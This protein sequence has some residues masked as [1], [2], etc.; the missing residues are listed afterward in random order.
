MALL[1]RPPRR[2]GVS[3]VEMLV[4]V[5]VFALGITVELSVL[6]PSSAGIRH[7]R[8]HLLATQ[9]AQQVLED[10]KNLPFGELQTRLAGKKLDRTTSQVAIAEGR[11]ATPSFVVTVAD[12]SVTLPG[13]TTADPDLIRLT[14]TVEWTGYTG[15]RQAPGRSG[16]IEVQRSVVLTTVVKRGGS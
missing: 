1:H 12:S 16:N 9:L 15:H 7:G 8:E 14:A 10:A 5:G 11:D 2:R 4:A 3:I 13:Q 6:A